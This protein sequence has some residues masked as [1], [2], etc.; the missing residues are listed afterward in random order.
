MFKEVDIKRTKDYFYTEKYGMQ[1]HSFDH[2]S[3]RITFNKTHKPAGPGQFK[4]DP[5]LIKMGALDS[6]IKQTIYEANLFISEDK[7][8]ITIYEER[9]KIVVPLLQ[10]TVDIEHERMGTNNPGLDEEEEMHTIGLID[11]QDARLPKLETLIELNKG[12]ADRGLNDIQNGIVV[13]VKSEQLHQKKTTK[14]ELD[15]LRK[16]LGQLNNAL[17]QTNVEETK[18]NYR[19]QGSLSIK[20]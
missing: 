1:G 5:L 13:K 18:Q 6:V 19:S 11:I 12:K 20:L 17:K 3:L 10:R 9:N 16:K 7:D 14:N 15:E 4:L 2:A 8:L